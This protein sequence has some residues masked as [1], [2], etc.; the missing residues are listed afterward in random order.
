VSQENP[1]IYGMLVFI[2]TFKI[3]FQIEDT[4]QFF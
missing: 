4:V 1:I 3:P 2:A